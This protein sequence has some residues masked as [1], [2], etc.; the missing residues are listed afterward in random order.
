MENEEKNNKVSFYLVA[1][2]IGNMED[3]TFRA[4]ET[5]KKVDFILAEDTRV[6]GKLLKYYDV[7]TQ[8]ISY[9]SHSKEH[10][11][12]NIFKLLRDGKNIALISDAGT[13]TISDPGVKIVSQIYEE[14]SEEIKKNEI[15]VLP[16]PGASAV[17][18]ALSISG[19][20]ASEFI[21]YGFI[22]HKKGRQ[23]I[24][25]EI[26]E[27]KKTSVF[28]ESPNR[29]EKALNSIEE[30]CGEDKNIFVARELTKMFEQKVFG[31]VSEVKKFFSEN[32]NKI[33]GEF[34]VVVDKK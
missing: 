27:N 14:F 12:E 8:M 7:K 9:N 24:F 33:R 20:T 18:S 15:E 17:L 25:K 29:L 22:P 1:T 34:V 6:S 32:K 13:P 10:T 28:Y 19:F 31:K 23:T 16:I 30:F 5:L 26:A 3:I 11:K 2:P 4:V 21:F